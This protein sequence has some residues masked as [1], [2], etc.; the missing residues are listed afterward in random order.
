[1]ARM[2]RWLAFYAHS[3][4]KHIVLCLTSLSTY[5]YELSAVSHILNLGFSGMQVYSASDPV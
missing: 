3:Y 5:L 4:F 1:M 2:T